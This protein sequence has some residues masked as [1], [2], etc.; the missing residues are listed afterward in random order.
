M[1]GASREALD[2]L[3]TLLAEQT[4]G[5]DAATLQRTSSELFAVVSVFAAQGALRRTVSDPGLDADAKVRFVESLFADRL[6]EQP[7]ELVR[8]AARQR[9]SAPRDV[10]DALEMLAV[11]AALQQAESEGQLDEVED[12]LFRLE[13]TVN[14]QPELR[15]ALTDRNLPSELKGRLLHRLLDD[16]VTGVT[17][18]LAERAVLEPRGRTLE[19][20]L[21]EFTELAARRRERSLAR[22]TSAIPLSEEQQERLRENLRREFGRDVRLQLVVDPSIIGGMTV[23]VGDELIDGSVARQLGSA[24]RHLTGRSFGR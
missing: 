8:G 1:R 17:L 15:A 11:E 4:S 9:W 13:R 3:R 5:A 19:H 18:A 2:A 23:R 24:R 12:Q 20:V 7:L 14:G 16:K 21:D 6:A 10:V 22:V